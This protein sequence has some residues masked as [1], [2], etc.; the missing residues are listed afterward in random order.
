MWVGGEVARNSGPIWEVL[1]STT[2]I[3]LWLV[4]PKPP[5]AGLD[6]SGRNRLPSPGCRWE[7]SRAVAVREIQGAGALG[8][9]E[10]MRRWHS[11]QSGSRGGM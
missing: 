11:G 6:E 10:W 5:G 4:N 9:P 1:P 2:T 7:V 3:A 8:R